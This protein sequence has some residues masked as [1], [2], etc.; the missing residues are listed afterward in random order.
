[1]L[2]TTLGLVV[3]RACGRGAA[4]AAGAARVAVMGGAWAVSP[5]SAADRRS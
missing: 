3:A 1:M 2:R 5:F 4:M